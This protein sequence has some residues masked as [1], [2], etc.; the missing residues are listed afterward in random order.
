MQLPHYLKINL[1]DQSVENYPIDEAMFSKFI[2]GK[3]LAAKL[4]YDLLPQGTDPLSPESILIINTGPMNGTGAP[5]S[6]RFNL[7]FKNVLTGGIASSN[8]GGQF[9]VMLKKAGVDGLILTGRAAS[10]VTIEIVDGEIA[11]LDASHLWGMDAEVTQTHFQKPYGKLVI[12]PAGENGVRYACA[13]S[14]ERVAGRGGAGAVMGVKNLKALVAY[15]SKK[16]PIDDSKAF[17][18]YLKQWIHFLK[19][20]PMTGRTLGRYGTAGLVNIANANNALPTH[21]FKS[22]HFDAA[23]SIS[24]E[25]LADTSLVKNSGCISCPIRCERRVIIDGREVKGPE[26]ETVGLFG[27]NID[28][29]DLNF[30]NAI[31]YEA[32]IL[33]IDTISLGGTIAFAMEL[34][35][36]GMADF[37]LSFGKTDGILE[38]IRQIAR[39]EGRCA[40]LGMGSKWLSERYGGKDFAIH[41]KGMEL[42]AYEP[43]RSVGMG[44]G[45]ATS[46]RGGCHLNGGY[47]ALIESVG[48]LSV[49]SQTPKGKPE[50][51]IFFQNMMEAISAAGFCLFTA[52][53]TI[54]GI[55][56]KLGPAHPITRFVNKAAIASRFALRPVWKLLPDLMPIHA[57]PILPQ[58]KAIE[59]ATGMRM[60]VGKLLQVGE[61][62]FNME[63]LF[64]L[65]EGLTKADDSLPERLTSEPQSVGDPMTVVNLEAMLP[66]YYRVRGWDAEGVPTPK[67]RQQLG[68]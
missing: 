26:Y 6:S 41:A 22:G 64:N 11:F 53:A 42:A 19:N 61:R 47:L 29:G 36:R 18:A 21:N 12:G 25:T 59:L 62:G 4:L 63:R 17:N 57:I 1:S 7:T 65:R 43:R 33:G 30:I 37:G 34:Q 31:N 67:K 46:N 8:C 32:D 50:L 13:V 16:Q 24:G 3:I 51:T 60:T 55:F 28:C 39:G 20:H 49:D 58:A 27:S 35:E 5:S 45:Y 14:G 9:G 2:G 48:V 56:Y 54:P 66:V 40:E 15:G 44:L 68:I 23:E 10:P 52:Q 38:T